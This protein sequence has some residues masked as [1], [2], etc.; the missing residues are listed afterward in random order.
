VLDNF[1]LSKTLDLFGKTL[2]WS[3]GNKGE[4]NLCR[5]D[6]MTIDSNVIIDSIISQKK[7]NPR[8][9]GRHFIE[10]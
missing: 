6:F 2:C 7:R 9:A 10:Y 5:I 1:I 8:V 3:F 4:G